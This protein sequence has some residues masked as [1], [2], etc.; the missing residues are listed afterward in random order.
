MMVAVAS[1]SAGLNPELAP[2]AW[3]TETAPTASIRDV[4]TLGAQGAPT[5]AD[6]QRESGSEAGVVKKTGTEPGPREAPRALAAK[7]GR[8]HPWAS[9]EG[10]HA[11]SRVAGASV[12]FQMGTMATCRKARLAPNAHGS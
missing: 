6:T 2:R 9:A 1:G 7:R 8:R 11:G 5:A 4:H 10:G 3:D 12:S